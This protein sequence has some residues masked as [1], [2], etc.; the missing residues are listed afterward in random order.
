[1][2]NTIKIGFRCRFS[3]LLKLRRVDKPKFI[4]MMEGY[5]FLFVE[6]PCAGFY[7]IEV[8]DVTIRKAELIRQLLTNIKVYD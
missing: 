2:E 4:K 8:K 1:M 5:T 7:C 6:H 3:L